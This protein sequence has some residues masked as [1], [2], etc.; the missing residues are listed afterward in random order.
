MTWHA[1]DIAYC[2]NVHAYETVEQFLNMLKVH[3]QPIKENR[4]L[5][6]MALGLWFNQALIEDIGKNPSSMTALV[7]YCQAKQ[8]RIS[9]I[10]AFPQRKFHG[11]SVKQ[12][13]YLPD[14]S[15]IERLAYTLSIVDI[16]RAYPSLF[17]SNVSISTV[18]LGYKSTWNKE[19]HQAAVGQLHAC[20]QSFG[21][22]KQETGIN[23]TLCIEM[24]PDCALEYTEE[25]IDFFVNDLR[26]ADNKVAAEHLGVCYDVCHQAVMHEDIHASVTN[27]IEANI[28]IAKI[29]I[30]NAIEFDHKH[31]EQVAKELQPFY[32]SPFLHQIKSQVNAQITSCSDLP[33]NQW[34]T[35]PDTTLSRMHLHVPIYQESFTTHLHTTQQQIIALI[36]TLAQY[37]ITPDL[38]VET[39]TWGILSNDNTTEQLNSNIADECRWLCEQLKKKNLL[40]A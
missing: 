25:L 17:E 38:E 15:E 10:N 16:I 5:E 35:L 11:D 2:S 4:H 6:K 39:Y 36:D 19:K 1:C 29:Q 26:I 8:L 7:D 22:F 18:P 24:E 28:Q 12:Q 33:K 20:A 30:S 14:W 3:A 23:L 37:R 27:I 40:I 9:T 31:I 34:Q 13:V 32:H 21:D